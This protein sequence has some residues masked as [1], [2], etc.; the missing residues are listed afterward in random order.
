MFDVENTSFSE[1][2]SLI[3][4]TYQQW[5][6]RSDFT[7]AAYTLKYEIQSEGL[8]TTANGSYDNTNEWWVFELTSADYDSI[9]SGDARWDLIVTRTS[10]SERIV[11]ETGVFTVHMTTDDRRTHAET[12]VAKIESVL[13]NRADHDIESYSIKSRSL[14]RMSVKELRDWREYY[15][16][17]IER[18]GGSRTNRNTAKKN[19]VLVGW[20]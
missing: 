6:K 4:G 1:P 15:Q 9:V 20:K 11:L 16:A 3:K 10:D 14:T 7:D 19:T 13:E 12:M 18:T 8:T 2:L 17:E 5:R